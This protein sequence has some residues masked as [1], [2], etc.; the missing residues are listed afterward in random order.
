MAV[1]GN[2]MKT[3]YRRISG[4]LE[5][6]AAAVTALGRRK[7]RLGLFLPL[8]SAALL[9]TAAIFIALYLPGREPHL[10]IL[11]TFRPGAPEY[12]FSIMG[13]GDK[14]LTKPM[15]A[16]VSGNR[17]YVS[18]TLNARIQVL[19]LGGDY[20][21]DFG[22]A[23]AGPGQFAFPYGIAFSPKGELYV[24]DPYN[25]AISIFDPDGH[26]L[27][28]FFNAGSEAATPAG[29]L[30][31]DKKLF[32]A[33]LEPSEIRVY[34]LDTAALLYTIG[35]P[36]SGVG[37][38]AVPNDLAFGPDG[39]LYVSDTGHDRINVYTLNGEFLRT[40]SSESYLISSPR[41]LAFNSHGQLYVVSKLTGEVVI[42]DR[43]GKLID[44]FGGG[45]FNLPNGLA[46]DRRGGVY[47]TDHISVA[48][49]Q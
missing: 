17:L 44:R 45:L 40:L 7:I 25:G 27:R 35:S 18:D 49:F 19:S 43:D 24:A 20:L 38:L 13:Q 46:F 26:F 22:S 2:E 10:N 39:N 14:M 23:G 8:L 3:V 6:V 28:F 42:L 31:K 30:I 37:A 36:G 16:A 34:D 12:Q 21:F 32:A 47:V 15:G 11:P 33:N 5:A 1:S 9:L 48:V 41:G 4:N 29:L